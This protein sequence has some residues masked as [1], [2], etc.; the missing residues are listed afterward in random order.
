MIRFR[1]LGALDLRDEGGREL[2][3]VLA[4]QKRLALLAYLSAA[5]PPGFHRRDTLLALFWPELNMARARDALNQSLSYLRDELGADVI[6]SRGPAAV[7][8]D[9]TRIWCDA[10]AFRELSSAGHTAEALDLYRGEFL[11]GFFVTD[12]APEFDQW[13]ESERRD[14][15]RQGSAAALSR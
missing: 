15:R 13:V 12:A 6:V 4:Q 11:S 3:G 8:L 5:A 14:L 2:R 10:S 9:A 7:G 1:V